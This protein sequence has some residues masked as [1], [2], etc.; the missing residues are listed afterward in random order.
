MTRRLSP[1]K[2]ELP[3]TASGYPDPCG[4][5]TDSRVKSACSNPVIDFEDQLRVGILIM[6]VYSSTI[7]P[8]IQGLLV[9]FIESGGRHAPA[10][11]PFGVLVTHVHAAVAHGETEIVMPIRT[12]EGMAFIREETA[13]GNA[14]EHVFLVRGEPVSGMLFPRGL[15]N[16]YIEAT[17]G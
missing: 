2:R 1:R 7:T 6:Y 17:R 5:I 16:Q 14:S 8:D 11:E 9:N 15:F 13:P 10:E 3:G 4:Y 12:M